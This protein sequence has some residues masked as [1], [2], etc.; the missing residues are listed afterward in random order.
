MDVATQEVS[1]TSFNTLQLSLLQ[2]RLFG[3]ED[4]RDTQPVAIINRALAR[5]YF[6]DAN[7]LGHMIKLSRSDDTTHEWLTIVGIV[8]DVKT[9]TVF[10]E[11]GYAEPPAVYRPLTQSNP[12]QLALMIS[13]G[14]P[15]TALVSDVQQ[16]LNE[17]DSHLVLGE[18]NALAEM[19]EAELSPPRFRAVLFGGF[20]AIALLRSLIGLYGS[21]SQ[22][23]VR[24][25]H[26]VSIRM[27]PGADRGDILGSI[28][29]RASSVMLQGAVAGAVIASICMRSMH[30]FTYGIEAG[31]AA[32]SA[33]AAMVLF[34]LT[35][36]VALAPAIRAASINPIDALRNQ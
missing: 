28:L 19:R 25:T 21:L 22:M 18:V 16:R 34:V 4:N 12:V 35:I 13:T 33:G 1:T 30:A 17:I 6:P 15:S 3:P 14:G 10:Q 7:P 24:R 27:A 5:E 9:S 20:A 26:E 29:R 8:G 23:I 31:G 32:E 11:M 2:G 36:A